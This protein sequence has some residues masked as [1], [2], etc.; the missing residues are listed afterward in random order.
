MR[1]I[2][3]QSLEIFRAV[4]HEGGIVRAATRL[5]RV[6]SNVTTR[7]KQLE[8]R[9]GVPLFR[10][11]GRSLVLTDSGDTLLAY[12]ERLLRLADEA[13]KATRSAPLYGRIQIGSME[14]TAASRLPELLS[15]F[16]QMNAGINLQIETGP[17]ASL[18]D[19]VCRYQL[20]AAFVGEPYS[21]E[22]LQSKPVFSEE[23]VLVTAKYHKNVRTPSDLES[24]SILVFGDGCSYRRRLESWFSGY[25]ETPGKTIE[26]VSYQAILACAAAGSGVG[27][28][29][30]SV[31]DTLLASRQIKRHK[32][33]VEIGHN[34]TY[35]VW[36]DPP[37]PSLQMLLDIFE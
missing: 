5:N 24:K 11:Q 21:A 14:S 2:D 32:L 30:V 13:E 23:L 10:R 33:P 19:K 15:K 22:E 25:D 27:V 16:H 1:S 28:I 6:Q 29:P 8:D 12:A 35:L 36:A 7:I 34:K 26:L 4:V 9:L 3:L 20:E 18:I 17:T 37:S 31:L